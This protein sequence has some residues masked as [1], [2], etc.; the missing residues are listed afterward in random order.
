[1]SMGNNQYIEDPTDIKFNAAYGAKYDNFIWGD[2]GSAK[3]QWG[4]DGSG[5][6][7]GANLNAGKDF[8]LGII[9][10]RNDVA[11]GYPI[12]SVDP[13]NQKID[14]RI[15]NFIPNNNTEIF[16]S[17]KLSNLTLGL[18]LSYMHAQDKNDDPISKYNNYEKNFSQFG[19]NTGLIIDLPSKNTIDAS[20]SMLFPKLKADSSERK[21]IDHSQTIFNFKGRAFI[22]LY[23]K[24]KLV[25]FVEWTKASADE[26]NRMPNTSIFNIGLGLQYKYENFLFVGGP[27]LLFISQKIDGDEYYPEI[28]NSISQINWNFG[29]EWCCTS[30]LTARMGYQ[31]HTGSITIQSAARRSYDDDYKI[32]EATQTGY[33]LNDG[34]TVGLG[35]K[36]GSFAL[37]ATVD[38]DVLRQGLNNIGGG[39]ATLG[40]L[41]TSYAF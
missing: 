19:F 17:C 32:S 22:G 34:F 35:F 30:W 23:E 15:L 25:P 31:T 4:N 41:S 38:T 37:D 28:N 16:A 5:Q 21:I 27:S 14:Q 10:S 9:L 18:G 8:T 29:A 26:D 40:Y 39:H 33:G 11:N 24:T 6:F 3:T 2:I 12:S 1:M 20:V 36:I 7:F 13:F